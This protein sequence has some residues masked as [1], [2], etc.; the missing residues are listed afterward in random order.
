MIKLT[1]I[2]ISVNVRRCGPPFSCTASLRLTRNT[3]T[4][5][6]ERKTGVPSLSKE[7]RTADKKNENEASRREK[8]NAKTIEGA[9]KNNSEALRTK[10]IRRTPANRNNFKQ[11][12]KNKL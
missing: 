10:Q 11:Q 6:F 12:F 4:V 8:K 1:A 2:H 5:A 3:K 9:R 7:K